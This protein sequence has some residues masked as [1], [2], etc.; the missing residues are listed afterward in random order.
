MKN[1]LQASRRILGRLERGDWT[2]RLLILFGLFVFGL[3][4]LHVLR[5]RLWIPGVGWIISGV[6]EL[7]G[8]WIW[9]FFES[10]VGG[11]ENVAS[12]AVIEYASDLATSTMADAVMEM[13]EVMLETTTSIIED[14][15]E[16]A[17]KTATLSMLAHTTTQLA[18]ASDEALLLENDDRD[19]NE[20]IKEE[21]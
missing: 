13:P 18:N 20:I 6:F 14:A 5:R 4:I 16:F 10:A 19:Y 21:L 12:E 15:V 11:S 2:D 7:F 9:A 3:V 1:A 8:G 17:L